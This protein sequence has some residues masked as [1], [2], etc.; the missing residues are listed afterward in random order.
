VKGWGEGVLDGGIYD[1]K[2]GKQ[3]KNST[4]NR[5]QNMFLFQVSLSSVPTQWILISHLWLLIRFF[6]L[7]VFYYFIKI[8]Q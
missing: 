6:F 1:K 2:V 5:I 8:A 3:I 4:Q 7:L